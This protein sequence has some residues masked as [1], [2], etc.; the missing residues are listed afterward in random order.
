MVCVDANALTA[1]VIISVFLGPFLIW[2]GYQLAEWF[3]G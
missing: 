1:S 3:L 2:V